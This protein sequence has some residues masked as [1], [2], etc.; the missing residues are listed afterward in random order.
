M[1]AYYQAVQAFPSW[2]AH[3]LARLPADVT[4]QIHE[5]RLRT[6]CPPEVML[7]GKRCAL[8]ELPECPE[9][10]RMLKLTQL[11]LEEILDTLCGGSLHTHQAELAHGYLTTASGCR[12]GVA[13]RYAADTGQEPVLQ[14]VTSLNFRIARAVPIPLPQVLCNIL[15][16]PFTGLLVVGPPDSGK[17]TLLRQVARWLAE[18]G[19]AVAVADERGELFPS[20]EGT[21]AGLDCLSG[22]PKGQAVQ[23]ALR[24]LA[25]QVI[26]LDELG[27]MEEVRALEQGFFSGVDFLASLHAPSAEDAF[28]R[29]Q[30]QALQKSGMLHALVVLE[31]CTAPGVIREVWML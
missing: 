9:G 25:P 29:P 28:Y 4:G 31:G 19:R 27:G 26:L 17:T 10:L 3:P 11:Q 8:R 7:P 12:V 13:G 21:P 2:L 14:Q 15:Q 16:T 20:S 1:D 5:I 23:M 18:H 24:T 22:L 6:G 30:V